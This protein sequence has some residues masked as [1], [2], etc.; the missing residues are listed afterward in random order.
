MRLEERIRPMEIIKKGNLD[1]LKGI[2]KFKCDRCKCVFK[3]NKGEYYI[4]TDSRN[5]IY[6][7]CDC[8]TCDYRVYKAKK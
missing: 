7:T 3:A 2:V 6:Y 8:P 1:Y 5:G 4:L